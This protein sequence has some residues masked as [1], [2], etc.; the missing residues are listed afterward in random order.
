MKA[1]II[2]QY[3]KE[4]QSK[5]TNVKD[6]RH[7]IPWQQ[8]HMLDVCLLYEMNVSLLEELILAQP[9]LMAEALFEIALAVKL[10]LFDGDKVNQVLSNIEGATDAK[11]LIAHI[12][13]EIYCTFEDINDF[14]SFEDSYCRYV[15]EGNKYAMINAIFSRTKKFRSSLEF[16]NVNIDKSL[17]SSY[18]YFR[19]SIDCRNIIDNVGAF[20][21]LL[22]VAVRVGK[23]SEKIKC[24]FNLVKYYGKILQKTKYPS[25]FKDELV[26]C[27]DSCARALYKG[28]TVE[29]LKTQSQLLKLLGDD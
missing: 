24:D 21:K 11:G 23:T 1:Q 19:H 10:G 3:V 28:D 27:L 26:K 2:K 13:S 16:I 25:P 4:L 29:Q 14:T 6:S 20:E 8:A 18:T 12:L 15:K 22:E 9:I 17:L 5:T 7:F